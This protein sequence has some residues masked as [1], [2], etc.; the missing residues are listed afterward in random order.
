MGEPVSSRAGVFDL[1][2]DYGEVA[3]VAMPKGILSL[4]GEVGAGAILG[5]RLGSYVSPVA[6]SRWLVQMAA[7]TS[8]TTSSSWK[9]S[10]ASFARST[11]AAY[12]VTKSKFAF[13]PPHPQAVMQCILHCMGSEGLTLRHLQWRQEGQG[14]SE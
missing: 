1:R 2:I 14:W 13:I 12:M 4:F 7:R 10:F 3:E 6:R 9:L 5:R 11:K 8:P